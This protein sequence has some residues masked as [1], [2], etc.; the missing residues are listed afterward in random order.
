MSAKYIGNIKTK[1]LHIPEFSDGRCHLADIRLEQKVE[2]N[3]L[4]EA[5]NYPDKDHAIF[6]KCGVCF[7]NMERQKNFK[8]EAK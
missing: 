7:P 8:K 1:R 5:L 3:S 4:E 6:F 2:F